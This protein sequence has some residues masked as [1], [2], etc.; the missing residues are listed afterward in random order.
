MYFIRN[1]NM[2]HDY[3]LLD[4]DCEIIYNMEFLKSDMLFR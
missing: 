2:F 3:N 1:N 4:N